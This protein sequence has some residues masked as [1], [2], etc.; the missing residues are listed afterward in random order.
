MRKTWAVGLCCGFNPAAPLEESTMLNVVPDHEQLVGLVRKLDDLI[1]SIEEMPRKM[2]DELVTWQQDD[3]N[4]RITTNIQSLPK[5]VMTNI[6]ARGPRRQ[7]EV[8][9]GKRFRR[10]WFNPQPGARRRRPMSGQQQPKAFSMGAAGQETTFRPYGGGGRP[11]LRIELYDML[12]NRMRE[13]LDRSVKW[14]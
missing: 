8:S 10:V 14:R 11:I 4:R 1:E 3:M 7:R 2:S 5:G 13:L 6:W 9:L 12:V